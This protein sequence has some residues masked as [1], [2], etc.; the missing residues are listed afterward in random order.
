M[1]FRS[2]VDGPVHIIDLNINYCN[3]NSADLDPPRFPC[4][5]HR[6]LPAVKAYFLHAPLHHI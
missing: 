6:H 3:S 5:W 4:T 1:I 2:I